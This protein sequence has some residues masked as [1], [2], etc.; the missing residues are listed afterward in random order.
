M[1]IAPSTSRELTA[2]ELAVF[3]GISVVNIRLWKRLRGWPED[4]F[5]IGSD[6]RGYYDLTKVITWLRGREFSRGRK[7]KWLSKVG[8]PLAK[9]MDSP[10]A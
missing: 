3:F 6:R 9:R 5:R 10:H 8:H 7:P 4:A 2:E 1:T